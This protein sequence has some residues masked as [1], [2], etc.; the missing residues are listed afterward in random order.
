VRRVP[1]SRA[2]SGA[3]RSSHA[4]ADYARAPRG[5]STPGLPGFQLDEI[6]W[7]RKRI[8][9]AKSHLPLTN[10]AIYVMFRN[11][12]IRRALHRNTRRDAVFV[13]FANLQ[14][15]GAPLSAL[16]CFAAPPALQ[17]FC[18]DGDRVR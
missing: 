16:L 3:F 8:D 6:K 4:C 1:S 11:I 18:G 9:R 13:G 5:C 2:N 12:A 7:G 14:R 10:N 15:A 17:V